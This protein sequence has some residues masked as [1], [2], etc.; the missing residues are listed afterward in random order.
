[1]GGAMAANYAHR[2]PGKV[3]GLVLWATYPASGD[4]LSSYKLQVAS[5]FGTRDGLATGT[6][7][8]ASRPLLPAAT[9]WVAIEGGNHGQFGWYGAQPGDQPA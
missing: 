1:M 8:E 2:Q 3:Q 5:I 7:I 9:H 6:K 4:Y